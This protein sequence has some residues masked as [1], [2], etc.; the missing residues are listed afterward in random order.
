VSEGRERR[1]AKGRGEAARAEAGRRAIL[2]SGEEAFHLEDAAEGPDRQLLRRLWAFARPYKWGFV[3]ALVMLP[4][5]SALS[6]VQPHL[7]QLA[8][9]DHLKPGVWEGLG[10]LALLFLAA[11]AAQFG[12]DVVQYLLMQ[13]VGL[14][15][16]ADLRVA[17]FQHVQKLRLRYFHKVP[18]GRLMTRLTTD[19][20]S[21]QEAVA[22]GMVSVVTDLLTLTAIVV[23][24]LVKD[25]QL[26]LVTF[27]CVPVLVVLSVVFRTLLRRAFQVI[28]VKIAR[29]NA[30]LQEAVTGMA[31][32]QLFN[33][34]RLSAAEFEEINRDHRDA[35]FRQ[36]RWDAAL[37][38]IVEAI[39]SIA[40]ALIIWYGSGRALE[41]VVTL[42]VLVAFVEYVRKF[43]IPI[44]DLSQKY[45]MYQSA[46]A[47]A[48]RIFS[49]F[50]ERD[51]T[52]VSSR[53]GEHG[54]VFEHDIEFRDV[55]FAY[56][57]ES[58]VLRGLSFKVARG[59]RVALVGRTGAG[60]STIIGLLTRL[61][62]VSRG[63]ILIDGIDLCDWDPARLRRL[64]GVVLQDAF[65]FSGDVMRNLTLGDAEVPE[66]AAVAAAEAVHLTQALARRGR[67]LRVEVVERGG[68]LSAGEK[69]LVAFARAL[70]RD[71]KV[72]ILDEAT[73]NVDTETEAL[74]Q[75]AVGVLLRGR[76]SFVIAHRLS[77]IRTVD[78]ILVLHQ[79]RL[80]E[81]GT[82]EEL[83]AAAG[84]YARLYELQYA[85]AA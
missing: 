27:A 19:V 58:W 22:G 52:Q 40:V 66:E 25:W 14:K 53:V 29:L 6:L 34:E 77:T 51:V 85:L 76:T 62:E 69:Q 83:L 47:A 70:A 57:G 46:M 71:P 35:Q 78:K 10:T 67:D 45:A 4:L 24:L 15:A 5:V 68:N 84:M 60:K 63:Q 26:A 23:I 11:M 75:D 28:R 16:L 55:W 74:I 42:G 43:F 3:A 1:G 8:I 44:R 21:L 20:E 37:F 65:L 72:L 64:F 7:L 61:H 17:L 32:V 9:D 36:I 54:H 31:I 30:Y 80:V 79:G 49:L 18:V 38:A 56:K 2:T 81:E 59:E 82:H 39:S 12:A 50:D 41:G 48:E 33:R 13:S 73:A